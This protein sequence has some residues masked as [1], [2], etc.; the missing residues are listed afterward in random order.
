M[1]V[2]YKKAVPALDETARARLWGPLGAELSASTSSD[3]SDELAD[4]V[5]SFYDSDYEQ[6]DGNERD[7][8]ESDRVNGADLMEM[9]DAT[10]E[11]IRNDLEA[12]RI[13]VEVENAIRNIAGSGSDSRLKK[14][15]VGLLRERGFDAGRFSCFYIF[16]VPSFICLY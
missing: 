5:D 4:L 16:F 11:E 15:V 13:R 14:R 7:Q 2:R 6:N 12:G 1:G 10:L 8:A 3:E 9:L